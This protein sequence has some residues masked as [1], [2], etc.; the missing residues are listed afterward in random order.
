MQVGLPSCKSGAQD[1]SCSFSVNF[2]RPINRKAGQGGASECDEE[3]VSPI[4]V[5]EEE[6][7]KEERERQEC[8]VVDGGRGRT[9]GGG[10]RPA[11]KT[12]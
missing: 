6:D 10:Q 3:N 12:C 1:F 8:G 4:R 7:E 9:R 11:G 2:Q 5:E